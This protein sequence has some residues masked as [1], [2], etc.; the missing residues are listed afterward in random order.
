[1]AEE[2]FPFDGTD[3]FESQ[4]RRMAQYWLATGAVEGELNELEVL[5]SAP[6][7]MSVRVLSGVGWIKGHYYRTT[8][9]V[10]VPIADAHASLDRIDVIVLRADFVGNVVELDVLEGT[11]DASPVAPTVTQD[12][13][14]W[15]IALAEVAVDATVLSIT[16]AKI[17]DVREFSA[18]ASLPRGWVL[19]SD[20]TLT[21]DEDST[22]ATGGHDFDVSE[23]AARGYKDVQIVAEVVS[24]LDSEASIR[25]NGDSGGTNY[26][27]S[28][29]YGDATTTVE[30]NAAARA[31]VGGFG[32]AASP[33][34]SMVEVTLYSIDDATFYKTY[35]AD[36]FYRPSSGAPQRTQAAGTWKSTSAVTSITLYGDQTSANFKALSRFRLYARR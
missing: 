20:E 28:I 12:S 10:T 1:M 29:L 9:A 36:C 13:T 30:S 17:T 21:G 5:Q 3:V 11:P 6:P 32:G 27:F 35:R 26:Q 22:L 18:P 31:V 24:D 7:A 19:I 14:M 15:E 8:A 4:W 25:L 16:T 2:F 34:T 33:A 23:L